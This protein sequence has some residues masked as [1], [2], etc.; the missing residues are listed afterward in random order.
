MPKL[1][2]LKPGTR[3]VSNTHPIGD[4]PPD[5]VAEST[6]DEKSVYYRKALLWIVPATIGGTWQSAQG[7]IV[8][9]QRYQKIDGVLQTQGAAVPLGDATLR[10]SALRFR[11]GDALYAAVVSGDAVAGS[12]TTAGAT[13]AWRATRVR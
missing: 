3:I 2:A 12:V 9:T 7:R 11:V 10:G 4:W 1:L 13:R 5:E 6:D 8:F